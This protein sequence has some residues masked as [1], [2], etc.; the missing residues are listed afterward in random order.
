MSSTIAAES[1]RFNSRARVVLTVFASAGLGYVIAGILYL[2]LL[3]GYKDS[4]EHDIQTLQWVWR[5]LF[6]IGI[7][8]LILTL[9]HR[10]TMPESKPYEKCMYRASCC[11]YGHH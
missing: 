7:V 5:L 9:Y 10:L 6:G 1:N 8:P 3:V 4:I 11:Y 2:V